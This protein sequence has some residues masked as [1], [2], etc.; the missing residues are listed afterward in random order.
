MAGDLA[1]D[2]P[3][4]GTA[5]W[6][7]RLST[8]GQSKVAPEWLALRERADAD[9]R[10]TAL[11][12]ALRERL[13]RVG[14]LVI[15]DLGS[16]T[17]GLP[18]WLAGRLPGP[19]HWVLHDHDS[20]LLARAT[21][22]VTGTDADGTPLIVG[23]SVGDLTALEPADLAGT[24]LVTASALLDLLTAE[25]VDRLAAA[26]VGAGCAVL[27]TISVT[28][29]VHLDPADPLDSELAAA[30]DDHQRRDVGGRRLLGPDAVA[31][32]VEA[33]E[34]R[35]FVVRLEPSPWRRGPD[36]APLAEEWLRGW[37][38]AACAQRPDLAPHAEAYVAARLASCA[39][40]DLYVTVGHADL[41]AVPSP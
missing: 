41:L 35:G 11:V 14:H 18:R 5:R 21:A 32:T 27:F 4:P 26:C 1:A 31:F 38:E 9:A 25:E 13:S 8:A 34:R 15:R 39:R 22:E 16:G 6:G 10:A 24:S 7:A 12:D 23:S 33:F 29:S 40:G 3:R 36:Q 17:G 28:G 19:Q 37:V 2:G 20:E 30:F